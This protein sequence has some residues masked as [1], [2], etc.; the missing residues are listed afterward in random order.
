MMLDLRYKLKFVD[1]SNHNLIKKLLYEDQE[2]FKFQLH[3]DAT[4]AE[5]LETDSE[6]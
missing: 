1:E 6:G 3:Q 4:L 2:Y 5:D